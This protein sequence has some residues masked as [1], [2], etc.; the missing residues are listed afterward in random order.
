MAAAP[1]LGAGLSAYEIERLERM[2]SNE[3]VLR[4]LG[5]LEERKD[6]SPPMRTKRSS[7]AQPT[8]ASSWRP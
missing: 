7:W 2:A 5:L 1:T 6:P 8:R 4:D 3:R